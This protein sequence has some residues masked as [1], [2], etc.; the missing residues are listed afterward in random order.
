MP[1]L[2]RPAPRPRFPLHDPS[3]VQRARERLLALSFPEFA[4]CIARLLERMGY[5]DVRLMGTT[6]G[7]NA[8]GGLDLSATLPNDLTQA[9]VAAQ[10]KQYRGPVPRVCV[11]ELRGTM[12]RLGAQQGLLVTTSSF[13]P[14]A[15]EA[16]SA[17]QFSLPVRLMDGGELAAL[18]ALH[19]VEIPEQEKR[20][21]EATHR[22]PASVPRTSSNSS[23][24][25]VLP[26]AFSCTLHP[27][28]RPER[29]VGV[30]V[31]IAIGHNGTDLGHARV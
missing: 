18:L 9:L 12:L 14:A 8:H 31:T 28:H 3:H 29:P 19:G 4:R 23:D 15:R 26:P 11:D 17:A 10:V 16:A 5:R 7:R 2:H 25:G 22:E 24:R 20:S 1:A 30:T 21:D 27:C 6:Q 13:A